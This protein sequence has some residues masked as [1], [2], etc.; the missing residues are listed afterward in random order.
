M[1]ETK[2][3]RGLASAD[4]ETRRR[5]AQKGG[6]AAQASGRAHQLTRE[7]RSRGGKNSS[8]GFQS[9]TPEQVREYAR[10]GGKASRKRKKEL[11]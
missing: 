11:A 6:K 1:A 7:E 3:K 2:S 10:Q 4:P 5:V 8:G 9:M